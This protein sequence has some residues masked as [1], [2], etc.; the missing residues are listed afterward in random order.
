VWIC[1]EGEGGEE[2]RGLIVRTVE[3]YVLFSF[4]VIS[5][6]VSHREMFHGSSLALAL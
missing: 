1:I 6:Q 5:E 4:G 3:K 2:I